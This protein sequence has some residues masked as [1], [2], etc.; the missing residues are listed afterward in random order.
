MRA[1]NK[2]FPFKATSELICE[3]AFSL[4]GGEKLALFTLIL[5]QGHNWKCLVLKE[6]VW[7]N[8]SRCKQLPSALSFRIHH[9]IT[10]PIIHL[11]YPYP[12]PPK[13]KAL[14][15]SSLG[16]TNTEE[17]L[18]TISRMQT[19]FAEGGGGG[20]V[21]KV[22]YGQCESGEWQRLYVFKDVA[23]SSLWR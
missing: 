15:L 4:E 8:D 9:Y 7:Q 3:K 17:R 22:Y 12:P 5:H 10:L 21:R 18:K 20:G 13:K 14:P 16:T 11:V 2:A 6:R 1:T 23:N 19:F